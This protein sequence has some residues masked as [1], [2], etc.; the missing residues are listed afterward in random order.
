MTE[1]CTC[2]MH[3]DFL[4]FSHHCPHHPAL[5]TP[6]GRGAGNEIHFQPLPPGGGSALSLLALQRDWTLRQNPGQSQKG[7]CSLK[8]VLGSCL[9]LSEETCLGVKFWHKGGFSPCSLPENFPWKAGTALVPLS[10]DF[11]TAIAPWVLLLSEPWKE[12]GS[13]ETELWLDQLKPRRG[14]A[15]IKRWI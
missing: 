2:P 1:M 7:R 15:F 10:W 12:T 4:I 11:P 9:F 13:E 14:L 8:Q 5:Q 6:Q 3:R